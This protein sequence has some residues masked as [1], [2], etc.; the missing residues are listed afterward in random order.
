[1]LSLVNFAVKK[2]NSG[3]AAKVK[4]W[5]NAELEAAGFFAAAAA[6]APSGFSADH[7]ASPFDDMGTRVMVSEVECLDPL[8]VPIETVLA[9]LRATHPP[10]K[11]KILKPMAQI[12]RADVGACVKAMVATERMRLAL[13]SELASL[14]DPAA[15]LGLIE[16]LGAALNQAAEASQAEFLTKYAAVLRPAAPA[17]VAAAAAAAAPPAGAAAAAPAA[18]TR[19]PASAAEANMVTAAELDTGAGALAT[20]VLAKKRARQAETA[21]K[22]A[23]ASSSSS[24]AAT[25]ASAPAVVEVAAAAAALPAP[26]PSAAASP[27][28]PKRTGIGKQ[29]E[30]KSVAMA[31]QDAIIAAQL[32]GLAAA[33]VGEKEAVG[34]AAAG[35]RNHVG[36]FRPGG[37]PCCD[38]LGNEIDNILAGKG[39]Y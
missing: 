15:R 29:I 9:V 1:M 20:R 8:C 18:A 27:G 7:S 14:R 12:S 2:D 36:P 30:S 37:C 10:A 25:S 6:P 39:W 33:K 35:K 34:A 38:P 24:S 21:A 23:G 22:A 5:A 3:P 4:R 11:A 19:V 26:A 31:A 32:R 28:A 13:A 16:T 17:V